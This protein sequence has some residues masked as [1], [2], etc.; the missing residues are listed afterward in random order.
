M[1]DTTQPVEISLVKGKNV[2]R[3]SREGATKGLTIKDFT[4]T[5]TAGRMSRVPAGR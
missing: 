1:W 2:L 4:L 3:F 5:P